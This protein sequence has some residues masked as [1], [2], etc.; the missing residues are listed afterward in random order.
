MNKTN[1]KLTKKF[2]NLTLEDKLG[3]YF[4]RQYTF[5]KVMK[6]ISLSGEM[7]SKT[8]KLSREIDNKVSKEIKRSIMSQYENNLVMQSV[9]FGRQSL[10]EYIQPIEQ[11][12]EHIINE[13][14]E[15]KKW[16]MKFKK[17]MV[18]EDPKCAEVLKGLEGII[19]LRYFNCYIFRDQKIYSDNVT[20][21]AK[22]VPYNGTKGLVGFLGSVF[23][24]VGVAGLIGSY[25]KNTICFGASVGALSWIGALISV[26]HVS[27]QDTARIKKDVNYLQSRV[28]QVDDMLKKLYRK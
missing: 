14:R 28:R 9:V 1:V 16:R 2:N 23:L 25:D 26:G 20:K 5:M 27:T 24:G 7:K 4:E 13:F 8:E 10:S 17:E 18:T 19:D 6:N 12:A 11:R 3:Y 15:S 21:I 22:R